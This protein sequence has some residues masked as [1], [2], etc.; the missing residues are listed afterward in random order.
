MKSPFLKIGH[1]KIGP[2]HKTFI[3]AEMSA[4]HNHK[5]SRA[6][7]I[8]D[9]AKNIGTDAIKI[10][11]YTPDTM[12]IA[13]SKKWFQVKVNQAW[14]G[15][16]LYQ[17]YDEAHT[18]WNWQAELKKYAESKGLVFFS[19][20]FDSTSV[21]FLENLKVKL[22]KIASFEI[23]DIPLLQKIGATK[24]PV[25]LSRGMAS[26]SEINQAIKTLKNSGSS[27]VALLHCISSYPASIEE[28]NLATIPDLAKR[29]KLVTGLSD[30]SLG[31][32]AALTSVVLGAS[33]IEKHFT[34]SRDNGG[35]DA[36]FS[37]EPDEFAS[38]IKSVREAEA[39][40]G[41][42]TYG[43]G[44]KESENIIFRRSL[45]VVEDINQ[46]EEYTD[47]NLRC[48][49]PGYGLAPKYLDKV[50]GKTA[51]SKVNAGT[52]LAWKHIKK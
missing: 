30:H 7:K 2:G 36:S 41:K 34:L 37:L 26:L 43:F 29:F 38:M 13:S 16:T 35:P 42:P 28:M 47:Q 9:V 11:T 44:K 17:L 8:I 18:P 6:K 24:K 3:V 52:P 10:Q 19:T 1:R 50:L 40:I 21:D 5:L 39:A 49:R 25:I 46:G 23:T 48:I 15:K 51:R 22:Y 45:F 4:N 31:I 12:T 33:I 32:T 27:Q 20:P 14:K